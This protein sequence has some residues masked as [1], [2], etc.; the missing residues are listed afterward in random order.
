MEKT[1]Y[2]ISKPNL[3]NIYLLIQPYRR[4]LKEKSNRKESIS[5]K[6]GMCVCGGGVGVEI[7]YNKSKRREKHTHNSISKK[8]ITRT[9]NHISL[10]YLNIKELRSSI[11]DIRYQTGYASMIQHFAAFKKHTPVIKTDTISE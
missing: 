11:N 7:N 10:I 3:N 5:I 2:S 8:K 6:A 4:F 1:K 9:N